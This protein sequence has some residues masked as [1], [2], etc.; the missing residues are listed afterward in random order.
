MTTNSLTTSAETIV[1]R[2][3]H[4]AEGNVM[5]VQGFIDLF[6]DDGVIKAGLNSYRADSD[7]DRHDDRRG[8]RRRNT[9]RG[10]HQRCRWTGDPALPGALLVHRGG[11]RVS[12]AVCLR[13][14][15]RARPHSDG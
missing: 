10:A 15:G 9:P 7:S 5:D 12:L 13:R 6:A 1:R 8:R 3:Y 14:A 11:A 2:A 4:L